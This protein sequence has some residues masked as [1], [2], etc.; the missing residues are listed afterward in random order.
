MK[1]ATLT[2]L[3]WDGDLPRFGD[4]LMSA[5]GRTAFKVVEIVM[6]ARPGAKY[7]A[8]FGCE[9]TPRASLPAGAVVHGWEWA[10]R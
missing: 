4:Y 9:R 3:H 10:K 5:R 7:V 6:P 2:A 8:R 1:L